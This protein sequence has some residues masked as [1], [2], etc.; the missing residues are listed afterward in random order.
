[1]VFVVGTLVPEALASLTT[2]TYEL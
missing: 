2:S 1:M